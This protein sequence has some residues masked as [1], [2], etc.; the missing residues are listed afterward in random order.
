MNEG[1]AFERIRCAAA[2]AKFCATQEGRTVRQ[3]VLEEKLRPSLSQDLLLAGLNRLIY[4]NLSKAFESWQA[5]YEEALLMKRALGAVLHAPLKRGLQQLKMHADEGHRE[6]DLQRRALMGATPQGKAFHHW[7]SLLDGLL[8]LRRAM[9]HWRSMQIVKAL[10]SWEGM[11]LQRCLMRRAA[12]AGGKVA[13]RDAAVQRELW[14]LRV[15][16]L[17]GRHDQKRRARVDRR[18]KLAATQQQAHQRHARAGLP[19]GL[20][21][22]DLLRLMLKRV[23]P[24]HVAGDDLHRDQDRPGPAV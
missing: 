14:R 8:P 1:A 10:R 4:R 23:Q 7:S 16:V 21:R 19:V 6:R 18:H 9:T 3:E 15:A 2:I 17:L 22:G 11:W 20:H 12:A 24:V 5:M 13:G